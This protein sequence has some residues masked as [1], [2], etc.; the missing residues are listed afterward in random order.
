MVNIIQSVAG[1]A[2]G[3]FSE[4]ECMRFDELIDAFEVA[5]D[6]IHSKERTK[7]N[8]T[9]CKYFSEASRNGQ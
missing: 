2:V 7:L 4:V 9:D 6:I 8:T 1:D 3:W 5:A